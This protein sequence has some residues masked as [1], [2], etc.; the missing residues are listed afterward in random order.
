MA[1][2]PVEEPVDF[3]EGKRQHEAEMLVAPIYDDSK[4]L[5]IKC[6]DFAV[7]N[8]GKE[9]QPDDMVKNAQKFYDF[10]KGE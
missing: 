8:Y 3:E 1:K 9:V 7:R 2:K 4:N 5:R 6:L 10:V